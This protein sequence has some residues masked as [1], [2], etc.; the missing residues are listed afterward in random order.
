[1]QKEEEKMVACKDCWGRFANPSKSF[2]QFCGN[3][4]CDSHLKIHFIICPQK[5]TICSFCALEQAVYYCEGCFNVLCLQCFNNRQTWHQEPRGRLMS[6]QVQ[7]L[8]QALIEWLELKYGVLKKTEEKAC[9]ADME[10]INLNDSFLTFREETVKMIIESLNNFRSILVRSPAFSGKTSLATLIHDKL[11]KQN[12]YVIFASMLP[13]IHS[14]KAEELI[15]IVDQPHHQPGQQSNPGQASLVSQPIQQGE[16]NQ[17]SQSSQSGRIEQQGEP[18]QPQLHLDQPQ[19]CQSTQPKDLNQAR[20]LE[21]QN[22]FSSF[23]EFWKNVVDANLGQQIQKISFQQFIKEIKEKHVEIYVIIDE[24]QMIYDIEEI[25]HLFKDVSNPNVADL[26]L[27]CFGAYQRKITDPTPFH[28]NYC[29]GATDILMKNSEFDEL[30]KASNKCLYV[31]VEN[32]DLLKWLKNLTGMQIGILKKTLFLINEEF[33][34]SS[35]LTQWQI[36]KFLISSSYMNKIQEIRS[37]QNIQTNQKTSDEKRII[38]QV[39]MKQEITILDE[40]D[41]N[42]AWN[43]SKYGYFYGWQKTYSVPCP[44]IENFIADRYLYGGL[45]QNFLVEFTLDNFILTSLKNFRKSLLIHDCQNFVDQLRSLQI[46]FFDN[47]KSIKSADPTNK[48]EIARFFNMPGL[49][50]FYV[51]GKQQWGIQLL[52]E[53]ND[54]GKTEINCFESG[55]FSRL[56]LNEYR[57]LNFIGR[58]NYFPITD[59]N[60]WNIYIDHGFSKLEMKKGD[61]ENI[62][63]NLME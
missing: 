59:Q 1:M 55:V 25:W 35:N 41:Q 31:K 24:T 6:H 51:N 36:L 15:Q 5:I 63:F 56:G 2:C 17:Q 14:N 29:L 34:N 3:S 16:P 21:K 54:G 4:L 50:H 39:L 27:L 9:I 13:F 43:L 28:F 20:I 61:N 47:I 53:S 57:V 48:I 10:G 42:V 49:L 30:I 12:K 38:K 58:N 22:K 60:L 32:T 62:S 45:E 18:I 19:L 40:N 33:K 8:D 44:L 26:K 52:Y 23:D 7:N 46:H 37:V 11:R